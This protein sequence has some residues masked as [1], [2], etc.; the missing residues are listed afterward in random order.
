ALAAKTALAME[1]MAS[2]VGRPTWD[3]VLREFVAAHAGRCPSWRDLNR[4]ADEATG[5]DLSW[6]FAT[7]FESGAEFDYVVD[8]LRSDRVPDSSSRYRTTITVKRIGRAL[9][10]GRAEV[11]R[12][13]FE[14]GR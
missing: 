6:F 1:T 5:L 14:S 10:T 2:W 8:S 9:F 13:P 3:L 12:G 11:P 4:A 7:V